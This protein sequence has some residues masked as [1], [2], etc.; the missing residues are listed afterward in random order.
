MTQDVWGDFIHT[1]TTQN[2]EQGQLKMIFFAG[3]NLPPEN[4]ISRKLLIFP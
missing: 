3:T 4:Q 1:K 2:N